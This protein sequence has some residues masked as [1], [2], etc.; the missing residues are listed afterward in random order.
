MKVDENQASN[1]YHRRAGMTIA[2]STLLVLIA[3]AFHPV[4]SHPQSIQ[5]WMSQMAAASKHDEMVH[6]LL[7]LLLAALVSSFALFGDL[8]G[9][10]RFSVRFG[11]VAY[12]IGYC[13][14]IEAMLLD[15]F[16]SPILAQQF[17]SASSADMQTAYIIFKAI[18]IFIQVFT[19]AGIISMSAAFIAWTYALRS[20]DK[21]SLW[22]LT[23][24][25]A[26]YAA[27]VIPIGAILFI[28]QWLG[29]YSLIAIFSI[30]AIW[31]FCAAAMLMRTGLFSVT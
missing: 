20:S 5:D 15:G 12:L 7:I 4:V 29:P 30:H 16:V 31:N 21:L 2:V 24:V 25:V 11:K 17:V 22:S 14:M 27:G 19:K 1:I 8:L 9:N 23:R 10:H 13:S 3:L 28:S 6:G 26:G 18:G